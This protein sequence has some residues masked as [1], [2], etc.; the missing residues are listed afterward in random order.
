MRYLLFALLLVHAST[1]KSQSCKDYVSL[2]HDKNS[3]SMYAFNDYIDIKGENGHRLF[4]MYGFI[5]ETSLVLVIEVVDE[6]QCLGLDGKATLEFSDGSRAEVQNALLN[7][8]RQLVMHLNEGESSLAY[9]KSK[10]LAVLQLVTKVGVRAETH[11][12]HQKAEQLRLSVACLSSFMQRTPVRD[13]LEY[14]KSLSKETPSDS[15]RVFTVVEQQPEFFGGYHALFDFL[16]KNIKIKGKHRTEGK[17]LISFIVD[18]EGRIGH[19]EVIESLSPETDAE[20]LRVI[21]MMPRWKPG[22]QNGKPVSVRFI[23][24]IKF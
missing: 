5:W 20:A 19:T 6:F 22:M 10:Q 1:T 15:M 3:E 23:L 14:Q 21:N 16:K 13:S 2:T 4:S 17:V 18:K 7:C 9:L 8:E 12:N 24:P 11:L